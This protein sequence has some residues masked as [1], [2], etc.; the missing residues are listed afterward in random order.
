[1]RGD[2]LQTGAAPLQHK[3]SG[4][5]GLAD[6]QRHTQLPQAR[7]LRSVGKQP[8]HSPRARTFPT[9]I[10]CSIEVPSEIVYKVKL[11]I[12][13]IGKQCGKVLS[14]P[15]TPSEPPCCCVCFLCTPRALLSP[16]EVQSSIAIA[17]A[18][19]RCK[20]LYFLC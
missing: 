5:P 9:S 13:Q 14:C 4:Q 19:G 3:T 12:F 7:V 15:A 1:M 6:P 10:I 20:T 11:P 2:R 18:S 16:I 8:K 17:T